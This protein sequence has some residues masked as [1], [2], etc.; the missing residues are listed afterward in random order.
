MAVEEGDAEVAAMI[1]AL[2][3]ER[4]LGTPDADLLAFLPDDLLMAIRGPVR[5]NS[6]PEPPLNTPQASLGQAAGPGGPPLAGTTPAVPA[7]SEE[8]PREQARAPR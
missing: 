7:S 1:E 6:Q 4:P 5:P 8:E 3:Q 2:E